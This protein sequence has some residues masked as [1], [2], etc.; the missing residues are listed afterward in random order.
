MNLLL[1]AI[2]FRAWRGSACSMFLR[3]MAAIATFSLEIQIATSL[4]VGTIRSVRLINLAAAAIG[5]SW[6]AYRRAS[7]RGDHDRRLDP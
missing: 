7:L 6:H 1:L 4:H 2:A 3:V 5:V